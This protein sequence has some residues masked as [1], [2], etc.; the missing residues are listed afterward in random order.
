MDSSNT[1]SSSSC[2]TPPLLSALAL[3]RNIHNDE[4]IRSV[5]VYQAADKDAEEIIEREFIFSST[6]CH[7]SP[8][9][10]PFSLLAT[11]LAADDSRRHRFREGQMIGLWRCIL[12]F[13]SAVAPS[14]PN[15]AIP[16]LLFSCRDARLRSIPSLYWDLQKVFQ[17]QC[18]RETARLINFDPE[19]VPDSKEWKPTCDEDLFIRNDSLLLVSNPQESHKSA[20]GKKAGIRASIKKGSRAASQHVAS[21]AFSDIVSYFNLPI[22]EASK[23]LKIGLTVLKRKCR[24]FGIPRWPHRKIKSINSLVCDLQEEVRRQEE[25]KNAAAVK[26]ATKR[27]RML[28][29]E[30]KAIEKSPSMDLQRETKR[31]RQDVFKRRHR[32]K[33]LS[34]R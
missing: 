7:E 8:S 4:L 6:S 29:M 20:A 25:E 18:A 30:K 26:A 10:I 13:D 14:S 16:P 27:Q 17:L 12:A 15:F 23:S 32:A 21:I 34:K 11:E 22:M 5:H 31:F 9:P 1:S 19:G 28:E 24:E 2:S 33:G 3:F